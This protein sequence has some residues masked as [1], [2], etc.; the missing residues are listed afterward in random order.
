VE[1]S[2]VGTLVGVVIG[3][4]IGIVANLLQTRYQDF[5]LRKAIAGSLAGEI[6]GIIRAVDRRNYLANIDSLIREQQEIRSRI[7]LC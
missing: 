4:G 7:V 6:E 5:C 3:G 2:V 1:A